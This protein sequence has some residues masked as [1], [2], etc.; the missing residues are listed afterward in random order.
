MAYAE[1][2]PAVEARLATERMRMY[3]ALWHFVR[4]RRSWE[5]LTDE[6]RTELKDWTPPHFEGEA[7][8]GI[9]FLHMHRQM[10]GMANS[11]VMES[12]Q[13]DHDHHHGVQMPFVSGWLDVPWDHND[14]IWPMPVVDLA[15]PELQAI[16]R[17]TKG[18]EL[19]EAYKQRCVDRFNNRNWLRTV[20]LDAFGIELESSIHGWFHM[21]WS[22]A[23]PE[24]PNTLDTTNDWLGSPFSSHVNKHFWKLHGWIDDRIRAWEDSNGAEADLSSGWDGP[25]DY[26]TGEQHSADPKFFEML[27]FDERVPLLM[28]WKNLL[29]EG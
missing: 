14:A 5:S 4:N 22:P 21:H 26:V 10:I 8:G 1:I 15:T 13:G 18:I 7:G 25:P 3:H 9:D 27:R 24:N 11:W 28:P 6:E 17:N 20:S 29:L 2:P 19:T 23:P 12:G 16:F